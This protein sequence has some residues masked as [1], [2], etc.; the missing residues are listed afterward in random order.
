MNPGS[1]E[2]RDRYGSLVELEAKCFAAR[3]ANHLMASFV[4][5]VFSAEL[6]PLFAAMREARIESVR[7]QNGTEVNLTAQ[8]SLEFIKIVD[9]L[10]ALY[11]LQAGEQGRAN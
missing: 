4:I 1:F 10:E 5:S 2:T 3:A 9:E 8:V 6:V 11:R 7:I